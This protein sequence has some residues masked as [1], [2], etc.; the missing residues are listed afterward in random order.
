MPVRSGV[1]GEVVGCLVA[2]VFHAVAP[3]DQRHALG[4]ETLQFDRADFGAILVALAALLRLFVVVEFAF[5]AL[6]GAVEEIDGRPQ[7]VLEVRFEAGFAQARDEG[8]EDVGDGGS[9]DT[10]FGQRSRVGFVLEGAIAVKLEFGEDVIG[11]G[12]G[13]RQLVV[14]LVVLDRHGGFPWSDRPRSSRPSWRRKAAGGPDLHR[15]AQRQRPK[16]SGGWREPAI[17][18]RDVKRPLGRDGK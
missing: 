1:A 18:L 6:V 10:G 3:L 8:V 4:S 12:C 16:Q 15:G 17:L 9:D 5:D 13:V 14:C 7:E 2:E 11:R